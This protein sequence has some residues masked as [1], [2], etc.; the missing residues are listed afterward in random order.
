MICTTNKGS[1]QSADTLGYSM[2][3]RLLTKH[4]LEFLSLKG[5]SQAR[6]SLHLSKYNIVRNH[7]TR[8]K[9]CLPRHSMV[10]SQSVS[11]DLL[12]LIIYNNIYQYLLVYNYFNTYNSLFFRTKHVFY[13][14]KNVI[15]AYQSQGNIRRI[16]DKS[17][18]HCRGGCEFKPQRLRVR[19]PSSYLLFLKLYLYFYCFIH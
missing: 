5:A 6:M 10:K 7:M 13:Y 15:C 3:V 2:T 14:I 19:T 17:L 9:L 16:V 1:D 18:V 4:Y 8:L 12:T 11:L